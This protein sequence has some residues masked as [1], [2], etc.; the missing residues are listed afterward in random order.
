MKGDKNG[1]S[2]WRFSTACFTSV[3][4]LTG[5]IVF[6]LLNRRLAVLRYQSGLEAEFRQHIGLKDEPAC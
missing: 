4:F 3:L 5:R 2:G 6:H 1:R